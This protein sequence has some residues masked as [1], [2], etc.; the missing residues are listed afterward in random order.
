MGGWFVV[1]I[2]VVFIN[3]FTICTADLSWRNPQYWVSMACV[4]LAFFAGYFG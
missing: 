1:Y 2:L 4:M 3:S